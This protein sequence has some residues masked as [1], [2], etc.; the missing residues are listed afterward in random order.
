MTARINFEDQIK[1]PRVSSIKDDVKVQ[2]AFTRYSD[3]KKYIDTKEL[4]SHLLSDTNRMKDPSTEQFAEKFINEYLFF[5]SINEIYPIQSGNVQNDLF[6][7]KL[8]TLHKDVL[9]SELKIDKLEKNTKSPRKDKIQEKN[10]IKEE[11]KE[12]EIISSLGPKVDVQNLPKLGTDVKYFNGI[13]DLEPSPIKQASV[14]PEVDQMIESPNF[15][16]IENNEYPT[17]YITEGIV[18]SSSKQAIKSQAEFPK[19]IST[20]NQQKKERAS[21]RQAASLE[22]N[23]KLENK[24]LLKSPMPTRITNRILTDQTLELSRYQKS[25]KKQEDDIRTAKARIKQ[26]EDTDLIHKSRMM[27]FKLSVQAKGLATKSRHTHQIKEDSIINKKWTAP[28]KQWV[29]H[30]GTEF[31]NRMNGQIDKRLTRKTNRYNSDY[32]LGF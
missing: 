28:R 15:S 23:I 14:R 10:I 31:I 29:E 18:Q 20:F 3:T 13:D 1:D 21:L 9:K 12:E 16:R 24:S 5:E 8:Q 17:E 22:E 2:A 4:L 6:L 32:D 27:A 26:L 7:K 19:S 30:S 11:A 25:V